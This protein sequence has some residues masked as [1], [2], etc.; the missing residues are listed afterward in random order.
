MPTSCQ[1]FAWVL[2]TKREWL[3]AQVLCQFKEIFKWGQLRSN[4]H[5]V[6]STK[7]SSHLVSG[8]NILTMPYNV[9]PQDH[10]EQ[11]FKS[12]GFILLYPNHEM[13]TGYEK[14]HLSNKLIEQCSMSALHWPSSCNWKFCPVHMC[15]YWEWVLS[16]FLLDIWWFG[17]SLQEQACLNHQFKQQYKHQQCW[18]II[19]TRYLLCKQS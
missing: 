16:V 10:S 12:M 19:Q 5:S 2:C 8:C 18:A 13:T 4:K 6:G 7:P 3:T 11:H 14:L 1:W 9:L 15:L 17:A